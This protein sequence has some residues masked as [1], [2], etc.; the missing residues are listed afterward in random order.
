MKRL[1]KWVGWLVVALV[2]VIGAFVAYVYAA[3]SRQFSRTYTV[4]VPAVSIPSDAASIARGKYLVEHV[5]MCVECHGADLGGKVVDDSVAMG[6]LASANLTRGRG[7]IGNRYSDQDYVRTLLHGVRPDGHSLIF[8]PT[9]DYRFTESAL[10][11]IIAY[12]KSVPP[13]DREL[14][15]PAPGP[16]ARALGLFTDFPLSPAAKTD[17]ARV[18]FAAPTDQTNP[19]AAGEE[20]VAMAACR[21]CHGAEFTG[22]GGPPPGASNITPVG[23]GTWTVQD[24]LTALRTHKRPNGTTI[25]AAMPLG[26][27]QLTD[28][29]L[30]NVFAYLKTLPPKG[31]KS[32]N[33]S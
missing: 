8:M 27:G 21:G 31:K 10:G 22:G 25:D 15:R 3:T 13:V 5:S 26:Y 11:S 1:L 33:Q 29:E 16:M 23:I 7:G 30:R 14:P 28:S 12:V 6:H 20:L 4:T 24:F 2:L 18:A 17:H 9:Q 19:V 32:P